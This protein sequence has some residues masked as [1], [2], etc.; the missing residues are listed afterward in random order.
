[1]CE[2]GVAVEGTTNELLVVRRGDECIVWRTKLWKG[3]GEWGVNEEEKEAHNV[4][5][6]RG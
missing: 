6:L 4:T 3:R 5:M 2:G 1:M